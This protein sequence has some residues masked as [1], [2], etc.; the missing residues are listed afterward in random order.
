M[1]LAV[2]WGPVPW[3]RL[4]RNTKRTAI[5]IHSPRFRRLFKEASFPQGLT[6][7]HARRPGLPIDRNVSSALPAF[8][9]LR[10]SGPLR[11][12]GW[13]RRVKAFLRPPWNFLSPKQPFPGQ[14]GGRRGARGKAG[15]HASLRHFLIFLGPADQIGA[16]AL[17]TWGGNARPTP[18][19][20]RLQAPAIPS[21]A[22]P[23]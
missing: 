3:N 9:T 18:P 2:A 20:A 19:S 16:P 14:T 15:N 5:R 4:N 12:A 6:T 17:R 8:K 13:N 10:N 21:R 11:N 22:E 23:P 1:A 7:Q